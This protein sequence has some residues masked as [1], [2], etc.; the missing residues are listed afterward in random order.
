MNGPSS[1][2]QG[3]AMTAM[4]SERGGLRVGFECAHRPGGAVS[5]TLQRHRQ[6]RAR[7]PG[8]RILFNLVV[9]FDPHFMIICRFVWERNASL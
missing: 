7:P 5:F 4:I 6:S 8:T 3:R 2:A 9:D 1:S